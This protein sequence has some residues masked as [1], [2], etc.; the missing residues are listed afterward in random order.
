MSKILKMR[1][2]DM[3]WQEPVLEALPPEIQDMVRR[4]PL[5]LRQGLE[6]IQIRENRPFMVYGHGRDYFVCEDGSIC[7]HADQA[8]HISQDDTRKILQLISDY[9]IY[10]FDEEIR[11]GYLTLKGGHRVGMAGKIVLDNGSIRTMKYINSFNIRISREVIGAADKVMPFLI[12]DKDICHT[13]VLSPPQMGKTTLLRDIAR[14]ISDGFHGFTGR[15]VGIVDERSEIAGCLHGLPQRK[16]GIRTDV[17]DSCP[18][19]AGIMMMIRSMSPKVILT[20]EIGKEEDAA[21]IQET[22]NAGIKIITS[23]H[24]ANLEDACNR[25]F[26]S[27]LLKTRIF[28]RIAVLG[29]SLGVGTLEQVYAGKDYKQLL[30]RPVR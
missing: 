19:A 5:S 28:D 2:S 26:L 10:A 20:D 7:A 25:L 15:K 21:A 1:E 29:D 3:S 12:T 4:L 9:S 17:L 18:K 16:V 11:N 22:L 13:L 8:Y 14:K 6:E 27:R 30:C 23:A 24:A